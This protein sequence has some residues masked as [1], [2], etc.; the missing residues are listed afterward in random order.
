M[1][2]VMMMMIM[3]MMLLIILMMIM[4]IMA[5]FEYHMSEDYDEE[6]VGLLTL[7]FNPLFAFSLG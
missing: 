7:V 5:T 4:I 1:M 6:C 3:I 2:F